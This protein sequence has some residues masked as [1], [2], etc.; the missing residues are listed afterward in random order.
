[1][2]ENKEESLYGAGVANY[3]YGLPDLGMT[4][5]DNLEDVRRITERIRHCWILIQAHL[6][7][8]C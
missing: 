6:I 2:P 1:M 8:S 5:L 4:S 3:S 7:S